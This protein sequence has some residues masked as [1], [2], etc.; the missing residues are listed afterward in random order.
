MKAR[1][2]FAASLNFAAL[3]QFGDVGLDGLDLVG[4]IDL[5]AADRIGALAK[6]GHLRPQLFDPVARLL[7]IEQARPG[8]HRHRQQQSANHGEP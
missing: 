5:V 8:W 7:I 4:K 1:K 2:A 3:R 6:V